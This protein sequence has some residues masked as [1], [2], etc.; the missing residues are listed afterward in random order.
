MIEHLPGTL[1]RFFRGSDVAPSPTDEE[2]KDI[3]GWTEY[4][5]PIPDGWEKTHIKGLAN[6]EIVPVEKP[7]QTTPKSP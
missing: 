4:G 5:G 2:V 7:T 3:V 6:E 1:Q